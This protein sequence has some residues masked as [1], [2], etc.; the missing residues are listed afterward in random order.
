MN[1]GMKTESDIAV[2][3]KKVRVGEETTL[4]IR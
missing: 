2:S 1:L 4:S 3:Q